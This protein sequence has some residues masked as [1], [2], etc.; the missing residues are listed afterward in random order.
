MVEKTEG[1]AGGKEEEFTEDGDV[2]L[3]RRKSRRKYW[4]LV[5]NNG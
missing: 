4:S 1:K 2:A 5:T 3:H